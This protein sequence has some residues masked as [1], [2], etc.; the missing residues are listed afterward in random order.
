MLHAELTAHD[1]IKKLHAVRETRVFIAVVHKNRPVVCLC[2]VA[3]NP[4]LHSLFINPL[5]I[6]LKWNMQ[7][8]IVISVRCI[9]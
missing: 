3:H 2:S 7:D 9:D 6:W 4:V 1:L 5:L 8:C